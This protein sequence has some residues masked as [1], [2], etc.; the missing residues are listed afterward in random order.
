M[1]SE[2][3][4][5]L[6][7]ALEAGGYDAK[8]SSLTQ[9]SALQIED[10]SP[11][12]HNVTWD[13]SHIKL[14]KMMKTEPTKSVL[15]QFNRQ[16]SYGQFGGSAGFEGAV[17]QE[18]TSDYVRVT[19]PVAFYSHI[20]KVTI[21][22]NLIDTFDGTK[23]EDR[24]SADAAKKIVGDIE[25][26]CFRGMAD[27]SN[28]GVFD[29]NVAVI[30][31]MPNMRGLDLQVRASDN[32]RSAKDLMFAEF[33]SDDTVII[34]G[35]GTLTQDMIE[36]A[37]VRSV[38]NMGSAELLLVDPKVLSAYNKISFG[39]ERIMLAGG[40][41][42][43]TGAELRKQ[44]VSNG[45]VNLE[46]SQFLRGKV[47]PAPA[48]STGPAAPSIAVANSAGSTSS[49]VGAYV[50]YV[51]AFNEIGESVA[52]T[53][54]TATTT[55][56]GDQVAVTITPSGSG[57]VAR[58]FNVYRSAVGGTAAT[59]KFIGRV[60]NS[61]AATTVF[62]DLFNRLPGGTTGF[63]IQKDTMALKELAPYSRLKLAVTSLAL[64]EAHFRFAALAVMEPRK[65]VL[66]DNLT[67][68]F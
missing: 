9:G 14:Q 25:F 39:K 20:R 18:E 37:S 54:A 24:A 16:L 63:L 34:A 68:T 57:S 11:V 52:S 12:M 10:L 35:G 3:T 23:A 45:V 59:A 30:A 1:A 43:A 36:D 19:V 61:G 29:G 48:K 26:D 65:N 47:K 42:E 4:Q 53:S 55:A 33:G 22:A 13:E 27:F 50:Y 6:L 64:P 21:Q 49:T 67:G 5:A 41:Q 58:G 60:V 17:G 28:A 8:P 31:N 15:A 46:A 32:E 51:S 62:T 56:L 44:W 66:I 2:T 40:P 7:K 38:L